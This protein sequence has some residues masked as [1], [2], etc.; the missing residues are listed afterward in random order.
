MRKI[1]SAGEARKAIDVA[2]NDGELTTPLFGLFA[3]YTTARY[4]AE[5][6]TPREDVAALERRCHAHDAN[7][8]YW[9]LKLTG[10]EKMSNPVGVINSILEHAD[11]ARPLSP[12]IE[13]AFVK[14]S[15]PEAHAVMA[16]RTLRAFV[17]GEFTGEQIPLRFRAFERHL[18]LAG[19]VAA[20][21]LNSSKA[22][23]HMT[24]FYHQSCAHAPDLFDFLAPNR[25]TLEQG[26]KCAHVVW[27]T[28][29]GKYVDSEIPTPPSFQRRDSSAARHVLLPNG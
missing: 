8:L 13:W 14:N 3:Y 27:S 16:R 26:E 15:I 28:S 29:H 20:A 24:A 11:L 12:H 25:L 6:T 9:E 5:G 19:G 22:Q 21:K 7:V 10:L 17:Q 2:F 1:L 23:D 18:L 4:L